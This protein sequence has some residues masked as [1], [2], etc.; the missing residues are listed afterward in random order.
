MGDDD[1]VHGLLD[2]VLAGVGRSPD[3][4]SVMA[5]GGA[6]LGSPAEVRRAPEHPPVPDHGAAPRAVR[7]IPHHKVRRYA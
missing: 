5:G 3:L 2:H 4:V 1:V 7:D 6:D